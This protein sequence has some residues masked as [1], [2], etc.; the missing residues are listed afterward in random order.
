MNYP[1]PVVVPDD[2]SESPIIVVE[3]G[4]NDF[5]PGQTVRIK[6]PDKPESL[7]MVCDFRFGLWG[8]Q[9]SVMDER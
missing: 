5:E 2:V 4:E 9:V 1:L 3:G 7:G 6:W 8:I